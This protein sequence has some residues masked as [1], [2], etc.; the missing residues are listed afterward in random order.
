MIKFDQ[1]WRQPLSMQP[2]SSIYRQN[3]IMNST[4][5]TLKG[6]KRKGRV[7]YSAILY[8]LCISQ[9]AG[10][11]LPGLS[12]GPPRSKSA[13]GCRMMSALSRHNWWAPVCRRN[14]RWSTI[15]RATVRRA[16]QWLLE[17]CTTA[18]GPGADGTTNET[19]A[20][21][22]RTAGLDTCLN[23]FLLSADKR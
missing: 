14:S 9:S 11:R 22:R 19:S 20:R 23:Q 3:A 7:L 15:P 21:W 10:K 16:K 1:W 13:A 6:K 5:N 2:N 12:V 8:I 17:E 4:S 18:A